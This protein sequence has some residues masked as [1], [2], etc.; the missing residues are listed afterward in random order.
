M[1]NEAYAALIV[2]SNAVPADPLLALQA[3]CRAGR[4]IVEHA[5]LVQETKLSQRDVLN[6]R[7]QLSASPAGP[8]QFRLRIG[9]ALYYDNTITQRVIVRNAGQVTILTL[10]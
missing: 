1:P 4:E 2:D 10:W 3:D 8:D 5:G 9:K 6:V 7:R